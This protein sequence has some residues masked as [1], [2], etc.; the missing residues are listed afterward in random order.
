[1][2]QSGNRF[3]TG[4][5]CDAGDVALGGS[6]AVASP[7]PRMRIMYAGYLP[8]P[9]Y[10]ES[11]T[12]GW[13]NLTE[14]QKDLNTTVFCLTP[15]APASLPDGCDCPEYEPI[16]NRITRAENTAPFQ[17]YSTNEITVECPNGGYL[18]GGGCA[19]VDPL[20]G[21][22]HDMT[23]SRSGFATTEATSWSCGWNSPIATNG[24]QMLATAYCL[25][26]PTYGPRPLEGLIGHVS[27]TSMLPV[28]GYSSFRLSCPPGKFLLSGSCMLDST[29]PASHQ[30]ILYHHGLDAAAPDTWHC[31]WNNPTELTIPATAMVT[32]V[33][34]PAG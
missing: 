27:A 22:I 17:G 24:E 8:L 34:N 7:D 31:A 21:A 13:F 29:D 3:G 6:C 25:Q 10:P 12:C 9:D 33:T 30:V 18:L 19:F 26:P 16:A 23:L 32:C 2:I 5:Y 28:N 14:E 11:W 1:M 15:E 20:V 4:M